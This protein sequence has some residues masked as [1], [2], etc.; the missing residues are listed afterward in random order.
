MAFVLLCCLGRVFFMAMLH[1]ATMR[2]DAISHMRKKGKDKGHAEGSDRGQADHDISLKCTWPNCPSH[3][4]RMSRSGRWAAEPSC[5]ERCMHF[6]PCG[7]LADRIRRTHWRHMV[8]ADSSLL[9]QFV[10]Q[11]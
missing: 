5:A 8:I 9:W 3:A 6:L 4:F 2:G 1:S 11:P 10:R 7:T